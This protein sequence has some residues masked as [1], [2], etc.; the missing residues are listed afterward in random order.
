M[1]LRRDP[2][3][4]HPV[5]VGMVFTPKLI[6]GVHLGPGFVSEVCSV[7]PQKTRI[8]FLLPTLVCVWVPVSCVGRVFTLGAPVGGL[9]GAQPGSRDMQSQLLGP[10]QDCKY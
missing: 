8:L 2:S 10:P 1:S 9:L 4:A 6:S 7:L 5:G 3:A